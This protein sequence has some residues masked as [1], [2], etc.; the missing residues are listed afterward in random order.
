M[1]IELLAEDQ[2]QRYR[3]IRLR[4]LRDTPDAFASTYADE[5]A[6][7]ERRWRQRLTSGAQTFFAVLGDKDIGSVTGAARRDQDGVAGLFGMWVALEARRIGA[8]NL[9]VQ[10]VIDWAFAAG[11][12]QVFLDVADSN[13]AA[14]RPYEQA[15]FRPT[16]TVGALPSPRE[17]VTEH[18]RSLSLR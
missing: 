3:A 6:F 5:E 10:S 14:I 4:A 13:L 16:G 12:D 2:W 18:E 17:H 8:G 15:G 7:P 11:F 1:R 9:L